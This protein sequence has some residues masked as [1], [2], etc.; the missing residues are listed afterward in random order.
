MYL[1]CIYG[2]RTQ[3]STSR[4]S[5]VRDPLGGRTPPTV[6]STSADKAKTKT[7]LLPKSEV[8][9]IL[10]GSLYYSVLSPLGLPKKKIP[11]YQ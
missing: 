4:R 9:E 10:M 11:S 3:L 7:L 1:L 5:S 2:I 8:F 6:A